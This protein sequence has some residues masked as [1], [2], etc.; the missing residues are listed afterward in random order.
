MGH[1]ILRGL[2]DYGGIGFVSMRFFLAALL[3]TPILILFKLLFLCVFFSLLGES[4]L[5]FSIVV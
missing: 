4:L 3:G 1:A 2:I 5:G